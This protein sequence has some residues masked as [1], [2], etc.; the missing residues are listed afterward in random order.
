MDDIVAALA[1]V[2]LSINNAPSSGSSNLDTLEQSFGRLTISDPVSTTSTSESR[3]PLLPDGDVQRLILI[4]QKLD[5]HMK[6]ILKSLDALAHPEASSQ[7]AVHL[8]LLQEQSNLQVSL[9]DVKGLA[10]HPQLELRVLAEAIQGRLAE[11][12]AAIDIY[13]QILHERSP[14]PPHPRIIETGTFD[15]CIQQYLTDFMVMIQIVSL[16]T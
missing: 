3:P 1:E 16:P 7:H 12:S 9:Q 6:N 2:T 11:F 14:M 15:H 10:D 13:V 4:D 8:D 5:T